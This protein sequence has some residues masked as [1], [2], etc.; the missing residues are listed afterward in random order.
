MAREPLVWWAKQ[1]G[2][3][4]TPDGP[5]T[6]L[7][8]RNGKARVEMHQRRYTYPRDLIA[9]VTCERCKHYPAQH[10]T[11]LCLKCAQKVT[12]PGGHQGGSH[13]ATTRPGTHN[14]KG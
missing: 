5:A 8:Y 7:D 6:L 9:C 11:P 2:T 10:G 14:Q 4:I 3:V 1:R 13:S 12:R